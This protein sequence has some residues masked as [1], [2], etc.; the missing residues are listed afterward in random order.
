MLQ[1]IKNPLEM[2]RNNKRNHR[3]HA[4]PMYLRVPQFSNSIFPRTR[5]RARKFRSTYFFDIQSLGIVS[6]RDIHRETSRLYDRVLCTRTRVVLN[7]ARYAPVEME[8]CQKQETKTLA[9]MTGDWH[10]KSRTAVGRLSR[11]PFANRFLIIAR[12]FLQPIVPS[13]SNAIHEEPDGN[14]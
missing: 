9:T 3:K 12:F 5:H 10:S 8:L 11:I 2:K 7:D 13:S 14:R 4:Y 1:R 6:Y